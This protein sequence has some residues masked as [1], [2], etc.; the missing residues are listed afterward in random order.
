MEAERQSRTLK[1]LEDRP[2]LRQRRRA[3]GLSIIDAA[4]G[5]LHGGTRHAPAAR[6]QCR[7]LG[8]AEHHCCRAL[9]LS[10]TSVKVVEILVWLEVAMGH[11]ACGV[12]ASRLSSARVELSS[13][14]PSI[15]M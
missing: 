11:A 10:I 5:R 9:P 2:R 14:M 1:L 3:A 12:S 13:A 8:E 15:C 7:D 6:P 4:G